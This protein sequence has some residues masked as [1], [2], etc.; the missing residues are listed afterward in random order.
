M[1]NRKKPELLASAGSV[2]QAKAYFAAGADAVEVGEASFG[3]R[4]PGDV[5]LDGIRELKQ[6]AG[7]LG[8]QVYVTVNNVF[9]NDEL[10]ALEGYLKELVDI[11]VDGIVFG[12][13]AVLMIL[14]DLGATVP[15]HW[16]TEMTATNQATAKYWGDR[17]ATR[18]VLARELNLAEMHKAAKSLD[19]EIEVQV[20]GITNMY[21]SKRS[22]VNSYMGHQ[23]KQGRLTNGAG[24]EAGLYLIEQER[25]DQHYPIYEDRNGTHIMAGEDISM[26]EVLDEL[27]EV[28]FTSLKIETLLK[29]EAYN[30]AT[31]SAYRAAIDAF[32]ADPANYVFNEAWIEAIRALQPAERELGFGF[33]FKEQV[34]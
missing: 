19:M 32:Y 3:M 28:D 27:L 23:N 8:K 10:E 20:H 9:V 14:K 25:L 5:T 6:V 31:I 12:D 4:L 22:L 13:P 2:E 7:K 11:Q 30:I 15:L 18:F 1:S 26:L 21:H 17:G 29:S 24:L 34:Y 16:N 33:L